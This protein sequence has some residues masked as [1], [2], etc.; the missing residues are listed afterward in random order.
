M[1]KIFLLLVI[2]LSFISCNKGSENLKL[3]AIEIEA[4]SDSTEMFDIVADPRVELTG[5]VARLTGHKMFNDEEWNSEEYLKMIDTIFEKYKDEKIVKTV[6]KFFDKGLT[7]TGLLS[8]ATCINP[9][10][11]GVNCDLNNLPESIKKE[12]KNLNAKNLTDFV[13]QLND[14]AVKTDFKKIYL[15]NKSSY[16]LNVSSLKER[17]ESENTGKINCQYW[18]KDFYRGYDV[19]RITLVISTLFNGWQF[20]N[21]YEIDGN[22]NNYGFISAYSSRFSIMNSTSMF[23]SKKIVDQ[24][25]PEIKEDL[26]KFYEDFKKEKDIKVDLDPKQQLIYVLGD[27]L[28]LNFVEKNWSEEDRNRDIEYYENHYKYD[29]LDKI[30]DVIDDYSKNP[31]TYKDFNDLIPELKKLVKI[32]K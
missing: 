15:L 30:Y 22:V 11:S 20:V 12:C 4:V 16:I 26:E 6:K 18:L 23:Y 7:P 13:N 17:L 29:N 14:F 28:S 2:F 9:D 10:F 21:S 8:L 25:W 1:K 27:C 3:Q 31:E 24:V 19:E 32:L 5:I